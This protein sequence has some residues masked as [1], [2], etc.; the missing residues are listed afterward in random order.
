LGAPAVDDQLLAEHLSSSRL[1][2]PRERLFRQ[3]GHPMALQAKEMD[4]VAALAG[5]GAV[6]A[7][8]PHAID[9]LNAVEEASFL[10]SRQRPVER[11]PIEAACLRA[12][13]NLP[14]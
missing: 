11:D 6:T 4:V 14:V 9:A 2:D 10:E 8:A 13:G 7:K 12:T 3:A 5:V 1:L